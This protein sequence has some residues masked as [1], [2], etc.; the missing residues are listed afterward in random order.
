[1][2]AKLAY[3]HKSRSEIETSNL[4]NKELKILTIAETSSNIGEGSQAT[5]SVEPLLS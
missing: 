3:L 1:M 5:A 4:V 2:A